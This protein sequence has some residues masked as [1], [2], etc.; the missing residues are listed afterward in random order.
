SVKQWDGSELPIYDSKPLQNALVE[1][2]GTEQERRHPL[3][4]G[5]MSICANKG[6]VASRPKEN[7]ELNED[8]GYG[9]WSAIAI[10]FAEDNTKDSDMFV[11][12][13]GIWK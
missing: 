1:Y 11:E 6:V 4:P 13:A 9:V 12:D 5:A 10:S 2:F 8:E 7:R 3:T